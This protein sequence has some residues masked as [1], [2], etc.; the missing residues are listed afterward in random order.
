MNAQ[1]SI[2][3]PIKNMPKQIIGGVVLI[4]LGVLFLLGQFI[5]VAWYGQLVLGVLAVGFLAAGLWLRNGGLL[6]PGGILGGISLGVASQNLLTDVSDERQAGIFLLCFATG[7]VLITLLS[8]VI[9]NVQWWP[10]IPGGILAFIG[11]ALFLGG[12]ALTMLQFVGT[13]GWPLILIA[14]GVVIILRRK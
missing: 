1:N 12:T 6:V 9:A 8:L 5:Q 10:L 2:E 13:Y 7:W 3:T 11:A 4:V 14:V